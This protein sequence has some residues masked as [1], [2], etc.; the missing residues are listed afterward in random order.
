MGKCGNDVT[1]W[2]CDNGQHGDAT[3]RHAGDTPSDRFRG[4]YTGKCAGSVYWAGTHG[5]GPNGGP[6]ERDCTCPCHSV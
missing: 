5:Q 4:M 2:M 3:R 6:I 1:T